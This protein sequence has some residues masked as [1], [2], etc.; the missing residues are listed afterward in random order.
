MDTFKDVKN[1]PNKAMIQ[2]KVTLFRTYQSSKNNK[3]EKS[4]AK[5]GSKLESL[6]VPS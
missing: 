2:S 4:E 5:S 3:V 1:S 6:Y